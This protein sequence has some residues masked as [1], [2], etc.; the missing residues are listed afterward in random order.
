MFHKMA[1]HGTDYIFDK[2]PPVLYELL[3]YSRSL[4]FPQAPDYSYIRR[5]LS[6]DF[7]ARKFV[8]DGLFEWVSQ[9]N[10]VNAT[11]T[12]VLEFIAE[13]PTCPCSIESEK[14]KTTK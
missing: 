13:P 8:D 10:L 9:I 3:Q 1:F 4:E 7:A 11:H 5:I 2:C 12:F 14:E 6:H